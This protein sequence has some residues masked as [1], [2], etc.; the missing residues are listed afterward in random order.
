MRWT[1]LRRWRRCPIMRRRWTG[2]VRGMKIGLP[3]EYFE[4]LASETGDLI[5]AA[6]EMLKKLGCEVRD[7][8]PAPH[9]VRDCDLL[10]HRD[11]RGQLES[12]AL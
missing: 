11:G 6:V 3:R 8:S 7:I 10:H 9:A 5:H 12:G 4:G 1:R 2:D